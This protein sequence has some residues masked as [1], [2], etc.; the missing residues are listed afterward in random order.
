MRKVKRQSQWVAAGGVVTLVVL[1]LVVTAIPL[2]RREGLQ[3]SANVAQLTALLIAAGTAAAGVVLWAWRATRPAAA[4]ATDTLSHAKDVL[5]GVVAEQWKNEARLRALDDPDPIPVRWRTPQQSP[6]STSAL[7]DHAA[8]VETASGPAAGAVW[9]TASSADIDALADRFRRTRRRRLVILGG[10]GAGKT[11]LALQLLLHL[12]ATR[13][14]EEAVPV[15]LPV[16]GWDTEQFPRLH[17]WLADRLPRDYPALRSPELGIDVV[18]ALTRRG[19]ILPVLDGLDELPPAARAKV[20]TALNR[21]LGGDDQ[22]ILTCRTGEFAAAITAA[23]DLVTSAAVLEPHP[24]TPA[25]AADYLTRC[26]PPSPGPHW[27]RIL[28]VLRRTPPADQDPP[29]SVVGGPGKVLADVTATPLGLWLVRTVYIDRGADP[30]PLLDAARFPDVEK[31]RAHL[32]D[33]LIPALIGTR[34]PSDDPV[35]VFCPRL[36]HDP[37]QVRRWLGYLAHHLVHSGGGGASRTPDFAWWRLAHH[38]RILN[39]RT[40]LGLGLALALGTGLVFGIGI[41]V[42]QTFWT[43]TTFPF[44]VA[45]AAG[46]TNGVLYGLAAALVAALTIGAAVSLKA[47]TWAED[48]PGYAEFRMRGRLTLL[49]R[50]IGRAALMTGLPLGLAAGVLFAL[51]FTLVEALENAYD[52]VLWGEATPLGLA[53]AFEQGRWAALDYLSGDALTDGAAAAVTVTITSGIATG[54]LRWIET[55]AAI[56][57]AVTPIRSWRADRA[58]SIARALI[59]GLAVGVAIGCAAGYSIG[60]AEGLDMG[61]VAAVLVAV[62]LGSLTGLAAM[63]TFGGHHAWT[64]YTVAT[65]AL[66]RSDR[67]PRRLMPFL[68]DMHRLGLLRAVGPIYQFRHAQ[69][70]NYLAATHRPVT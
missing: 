22:L 28:T 56:E 70:Q 41:A 12:L 35:D 59:T 48:S 60:R 30:A 25:A 68:D 10:P 36:G 32:F 4:P 34:P 67:L 8:N 11:T 64:A 3:T 44:P 58:L 13:T 55:P 39:L 37:D 27:Q 5:A 17:N 50:C 6:H 29:G 63:L 21:S 47:R 1:L 43:A 20:I 2:G 15:M 19:H 14:P 33:Q 52:E 23:A 62:P 51:S 26:L 69:L 54:L 18:R 31:L 45:L 40:R 57:Q 16:A 24:L 38:A 66:S 53:P 61:L 9:W 46:L 7:M 49:I 65:V 42:G